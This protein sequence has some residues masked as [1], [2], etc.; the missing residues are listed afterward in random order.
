MDLENDIG[1]LYNVLSKKYIKTKQA[2]KVTIVKEETAETKIFKKIREIENEKS[3][4]NK[5]LI[6]GN[7][8]E[9]TFNELREELDKKKQKLE[10]VLDVISIS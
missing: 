5:K 4:L 2:P 6:E 1:E 10:T 3:T 7:L 8:S 9:K